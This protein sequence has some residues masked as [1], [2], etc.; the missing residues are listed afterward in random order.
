MKTSEIHRRFMAVHPL[1]D[2]ATALRR[3]R[4]LLCA[5]RAKKISGG[6][7]AS[8]FVEGRDLQDV[9]LA[10]HLV[11]VGFATSFATEVIRTRPDSKVKELI[12]T[13]AG[14]TK[15]TVDLAWLFAAIGD[16][17]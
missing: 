16:Q 11:T 14:G 10:L 13:F 2:S 8:Q 5:G 17:S 7:T 12:V 9:F 1:E 4:F 3:L 15:L 6:K